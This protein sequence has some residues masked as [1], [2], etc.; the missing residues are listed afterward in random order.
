MVEPLADDVKVEL[1]PDKV[2]ISRP[3]GLTLSASLQTLLHGSGLRP[4]MFDS[5]LWGFDRQ[6][7]YTERQSK[8]IS[9]AAEAPDGKRL[10]PRLDL[11]RFYLARE[12]YPEAKGVL[13]VALTEEHPAAEKVSAT[14]CAPWPKS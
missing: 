5:Q 12:M 7:S 8:L 14:C 9:A 1:Q 2:V 3:L 4:V 6:A 10:V 13:D 11:A